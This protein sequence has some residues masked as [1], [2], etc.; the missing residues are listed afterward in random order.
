M[1]PTKHFSS[2]IRDNIVIDADINKD[3]RFKHFSS[4]WARLFKV[5]SRS[6]ER[7][8]ASSSAKT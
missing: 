1:F 7:L 6:T 2:H 5:S 4:A 3:S 8:C